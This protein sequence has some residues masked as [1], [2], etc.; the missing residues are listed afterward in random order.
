MNRRHPSRAFTLIELL[1]VVAIIALLISILL[2]TLSR[3]K[4]QAR[5]GACLANL[6]S[7]AQSGIS[8]CM[9]KGNPVFAHRFPGVDGGYWVD[10]ELQDF[11][12]W[13]EYIWGG[14]VPDTRRIDWD[15]TQGNFNPAA[16]RTDTYIILPVNRPMNKYLDPEVTWSDPERVKGNSQRYLKPMDLPAYF[17]CPSDCTAAMPETGADDVISDA[18]TPFQTW[19]WWGNSYPINTYWGYAYNNQGPPNWNTYAHVID[20][21]KGRRLINSKND[22]GAAEFILFYENQFNFAAESAVPRGYDAGDESKQVR[23]WHKQDNMH[24]AG[25]LDGHASYQYFDTTFINGPGWTTWP[26]P[27]WDPF[28]Q[29]YEDR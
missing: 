21:A 14:G 17:K 10:G 24:A 9:D 12:L 19:R 28:W 4:E 2:P 5:I 6:R 18:D 25:F 16:Y 15:D 26:N 11:N 1:V 22:K 3:A 13:T 8:Y 20:A 23:G 27:P 29:P 7:L